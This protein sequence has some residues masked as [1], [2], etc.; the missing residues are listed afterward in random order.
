MNER[1]ASSA[2]AFDWDSQRRSTACITQRFHAAPAH[3]FSTLCLAGVGVPPAVDP[4]D[5]LKER[6]AIQRWTLAL[7]SP[8]PWKASAAIERPKN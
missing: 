4:K 5:E 1:H 3:G 7:Q 6:N 8:Q 2:A